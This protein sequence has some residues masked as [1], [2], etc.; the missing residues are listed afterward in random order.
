MYCKILDEVIKEMKG[1]EIQEEPDVQI[2]LDISSYIP[3][4]FIENSTQKIEIY[5]NIALCKTEEDIQN[6]IDDIIDR[7]GQIPEEIENLLEITRIKNL[8]KKI[9]IIKLIQKNNKILFYIDK[10][11]YNVENVDKLIKK[12]TNRIQFSPGVNSYI[13]YHIKEENKIIDEIKEFL[14]NANNHK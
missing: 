7:Y 1:I 8:C 14:V 5:Q 4:E 9:G 13:T 2:D 3:D 11:R 10:T 12:Y 6:V